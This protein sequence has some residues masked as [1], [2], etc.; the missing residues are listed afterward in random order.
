MTGSAKQSILQCGRSWIASSIALRATA[1]AV[2]ASAPRNDGSGAWIQFS[3]SKHTPAFPRRAA[4]GLCVDF[5]PSKTRGRRESR[6][7]AAPAVSCANGVAKAH[8]SIQVQRRASGFPCAVV[9]GLFRDLP[10]EPSSLATVAREKLVLT[11]LAPASGART[12]RLRRPRKLAFVSSQAPRP[13]HPTA[14]S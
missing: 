3:N 13:P 12:T 1:D 8:M 9:Y 10:G 11:N 6:V 14:R 7:R 2:V 5:L 4:P